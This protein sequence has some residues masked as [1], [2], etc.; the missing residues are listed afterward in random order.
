MSVFAMSSSI[1]LKVVRRLLVILAVAW[2]IDFLIVQRLA[3]DN[4]TI[5]K[6][7]EI[8]IALLL[9]WRYCMPVAPRK[10]LREE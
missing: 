5:G 7:V 4:F 8:V 9:A 2:L 1:A 10:S 3:D 6:Q